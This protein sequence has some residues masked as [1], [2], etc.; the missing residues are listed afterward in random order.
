MVERIKNG[1][2]WIGTYHEFHAEFVN[3]IFRD[4]LFVVARGDM[5]NME[6]AENILWSKVIVELDSRALSSKRRLAR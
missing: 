2:L 1:R 5:I 3:S 6:E 4:D